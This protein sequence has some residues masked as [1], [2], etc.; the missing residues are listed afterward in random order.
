MLIDCKTIFFRTTHYQSAWRLLLVPKLYG[1][2][3]KYNNQNYVDEQR[4]FFFILV[5]LK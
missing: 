2:V 3:Q 4:V 5:L 1:T